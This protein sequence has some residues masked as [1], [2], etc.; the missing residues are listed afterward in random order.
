MFRGVLACI[1]NLIHALHINTA[2][3]PPIY[4]L[5][6]FIKTDL[7]VQGTFIAEIACSVYSVASF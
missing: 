6:L 5:L 3:K 1:S 2:Q 4:E 7:N